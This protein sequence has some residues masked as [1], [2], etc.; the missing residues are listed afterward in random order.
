MNEFKKPSSRP[1]GPSRLPVPPNLL[2]RRD[3]LKIAGGSLA[4]LPAVAGPFFAAD[5]PLAKIEHFV[6]EDKKLRPEWVKA[7]FQK[8]ERRVFRGEAL[9][10]IGMPVGGICA[11]QV[12]LGG[13]GRLYH[14]DI[15]NQHNFSGYGATN[16]EYRT[17]QSPLAQGFS[18]IVEEE[19]KKATISQLTRAT[20]HTAFIGEYPI[21]LVS[22]N[23]PTD[24][25]QVTLEAFSPFIP[26]NT[27]DSALP[28]TILSFTLENRG[29]REV[30]AA[31]LGELENAV[32]L[33][34]SK[35]LPGVRGNQVHRRPGLTFLESS[36]APPPPGRE[37][38]ESPPEVF[39]DFE[40]EDYGDWTVE[41]EAFGKRP[42]KGT[43]PN[44][45]EVSGFRGKGLVNTFLNGDGP[46]GQLTS[47]E[48]EIKRPFIN[49]LVG[50]GGHAGKTCIDLLVDGKTA[51]TAAGKDN[52]RLAWSSWEVR[53]L[54]GKKARIEIADRESGGWGH[55][56][57]DQIE[58]ADRPHPSRSGPL[59][60]QNDFGTM[61]L[62][63][64]GSA[65][66]VE[67]DASKEIH[68]APRDAANKPFGERLV[69]SL[70]KR[71]A[72]KPGEKRT[73]VF[74]VIWCFPNH[75]RGQAYA[76]RFSSA[77]A[78]AEYIEKNLELL[79]KETRLWRDTY[80]DSTLPYWLLNR[81]HAPVSTLATTTVQWW[82]NGQFWAW[83]GVG[84][85]HGTCAHVWNYEHAMAR[86]FPELE[87]S[88]REMQDFGMG[89][90]AATGLVGFRG[91]REY[92]A[93]GQCGTILKA[94]REH[95]VSADEGFL[96]RNWP[97]IKKAME[98]ILRQDGN[99][100]GLIE[101]SQH[102]TYDINF[103]GPN[104][105]VGSL[106]LAA[107]RAGE[108]M[109]KRAG[110]AD[111]AA[112]LRR[113]FESGS[114]LSMERLYNGEHFI[115]VVD[116]KKHP[117]NQ[118]GEGCL[119]DQLF[120]QGWAHQLGLGYLYPREAVHQALR[121]IYKYN[122][123]PDVGPHN[124]AHRPER[125]FARPGEA[126][127][128]TCTWPKSEYLKEGVRYREEVWTGI[129][130]Q[131]AGHLLYEGYLTEGLAL[132][133]GVDER[134]DG[135]KHNPFNEVECG[136]H[137]A[138]ALASWGC[139]LALEGFEHDGPAG[140]IGFA[141]RLAP[142]DFR[143]AFT[144]AAGWGTFGQKR[145]EGEQL[146]SLRLRWGS[147]RLREVDLELPPAL[148]GKAAPAAA[149][150]G[151]AVAARA[152]SRGD[153]KVAVHLESEVNLRAGDTLT[154]TFKS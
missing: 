1:S 35:E 59:S 70:G 116:Q 125:W 26:L 88:V 128:F 37:K 150:N 60:A 19:G 55:I 149:L 117:Q 84:C 80:Y 144:A 10:T 68:G 78:V 75:P 93:D 111:F 54:I 31:L 15:F 71:L 21:G 4:A 131:V 34:S 100:D 76:N 110:E 45:Q 134:Y 11:G 140:R 81:L 89:F 79:V 9:K 146:N 95:L 127:L 67:A 126:G 104:T 49:F 106:Y 102:N 50:G 41:G 13:D 64:L 119:S 133:R 77:L 113:V 129:E 132:I 92:A 99:G 53:E 145:S 12:Y 148:S 17:P 58:F 121:S 33:H 25:L 51:R 115:Q 72:L 142:E 6:P 130:Y 141:P 3:F 73:I 86:L 36:A 97:S 8:G 135:A 63:L 147:L 24:P 85:C 124:A 137:Y 29:E 101:N 154:I 14:W 87:R 74:L 69:G 82:K 118:Y 136:D 40:G 107:L 91:G 27:V 94:Y 52:E 152:E 66:G 39:A 30:K 120:G 38:P 56:N 5:L 48:F 139:L 32:C 98:F 20:E 83:E 23:A 103:E 105:F 47:P 18:L 151:Q 143:A 96:K 138:R 112:R 7:L 123:T 28:A 122:W 62:G 22:F 90:D 16:Y 42:A 43:L 65:D 114:K 153:G 109:A 108:E 61:G 57:I 2:P 46:R 44:Q